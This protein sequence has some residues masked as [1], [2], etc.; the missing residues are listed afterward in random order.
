M[1]ESSMSVLWWLKAWLEERYMP[2]RSSAVNAITRS[3][4]TE[5]GDRKIT[6][7]AVSPGPVDTDLAQAVNTAE[8][9]QRMVSRT[10]LGRL[11]VP[12]DIARAIAFLAADDAAWITGQIIGVD[13]GFRF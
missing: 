10:P 4:A 12:D 5:L 2:Q 8:S 7:N 1:V 6:V 13:G 9:F 11:G 3:L